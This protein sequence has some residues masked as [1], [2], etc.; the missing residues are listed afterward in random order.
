MEFFLRG[1]NTIVK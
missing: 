1:H